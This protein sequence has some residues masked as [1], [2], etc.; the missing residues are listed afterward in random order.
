MGVGKHLELDMSRPQQVLLHQY[1]VVA[2]TGGGFALA[3]RE[4]RGKVFGPVDAPHA[5]TAAT[6]TGLDE[7]W[8]SDLRGGL[9]QP[10]RIL[11]LAVIARR[12]QHAGSL[13]Q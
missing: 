7:H 12:E 10:L 11:I 8:V 9:L 2:E 13:Q 1:A 3:A 6:G 5:A 4:R